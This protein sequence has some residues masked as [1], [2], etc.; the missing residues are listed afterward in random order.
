MHYVDFDK[1]QSDILDFTPGVR[2]ESIIFYDDRFIIY[3][4]MYL[5][6]T[7]HINDIISSSGSIYVKKYY[8]QIFIKFI[9][10]NFIVF[11]QKLLFS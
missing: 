10:S 6:A 1:C 2:Q 3:I 5:Y 4:Y 9:K 7:C 11:R 8:L